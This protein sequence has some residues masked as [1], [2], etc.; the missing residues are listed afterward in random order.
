MCSALFRKGLDLRVRCIRQ[1][2]VLIV[3]VFYPLHRVFRQADKILG[4]ILDLT[5]GHPGY[6]NNAL[7]RGLNITAERNTSSGHGLGS[8]TRFSIGAG[9]IPYSIPVTHQLRTGSA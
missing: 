9:K 1:E 4:H 2:M 7:H 3:E 8:I 5:P 6:F